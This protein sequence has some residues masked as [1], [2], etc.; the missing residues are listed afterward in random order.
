MEFVKIFLVVCGYLVA[1]SSLC[2]VVVLTSLKYHSFIYHDLKTNR[3]KVIHGVILVTSL[4]SVL[5]VILLVATYSL[6]ITES[7]II[8]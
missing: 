7:W 2:T 1:C 6:K 5:V 8:K 3:L 4:C